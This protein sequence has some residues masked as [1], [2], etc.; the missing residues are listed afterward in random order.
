MK[1]ISTVICVTLFVLMMLP[2]LTTSSPPVVDG[3]LMSLDVCDHA[4][5]ADSIGNDDGPALHERTWQPLPPVF[6][7]YAMVTAPLD[8]P[9]LFAFR[10]EHPPRG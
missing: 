7:Y 8:N 9:F 5:D 3:T 1:T 10:E 6:C 2:L 4:S